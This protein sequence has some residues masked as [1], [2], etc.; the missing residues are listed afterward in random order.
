MTRCTDRAA[1][2]VV[3]LWAAGAG[4]AQAPP[5]GRS[6]TD[7]KTSVEFEVL[8]PP[9]GSALNAQKWGPLF[10]TV[11]ATVRFRQPLL[12]DKPGINEKTRGTLRTVTVTG[13][14][15]LDGK[16]SFPG[17]SFSASE[18][19][20]LSEWVNELKTY[21]ALG[22]PTGKPVW[23]LS[24]E[25]FDKL[26]KALSAPVAGEVEDLDLKAAISGLGLPAAY[27]VRFHSSAETLLTGRQPLPPVRQTLAG[28]SGG[29]ALAIVLADC[30]LGFRPLRT[31]AGQI[32]L[33]VQPLKDMTDPWPVGWEADPSRPRNDLAPELFKMVNVGFDKLPLADV[34]DA[35]EQ[36]SGVPIIVDHERCRQKEIDLSA[37][38][39]SYPQRRTAW[40]ILIRTVVQQSRLTREIKTDEAGR[41][42]VHVYPFEAKAAA[43]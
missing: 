12:D 31:P 19:G 10:E 9:Q 18:S 6:A 5:A 8:V 14:M 38:T 35:A 7:V 26:Y 16:L 28:F 20:K 1:V 36:A 3:G 37:I 25:Q 27:P 32:E 42:F 33:V 22:A 4:I 34:L 2:V 40:S 11:G 30:G 43:R 39:V 24:E 21:G 29:T 23:G 15:D 13:K 41:V 17:R